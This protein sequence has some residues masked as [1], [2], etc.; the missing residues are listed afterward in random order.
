MHKRSRLAVRRNKEKRKAIRGGPGVSSWKLLLALLAGIIIART[1]VGDAVWGAMIASAAGADIWHPESVT[2]A[3]LGVEDRA[4]ET[5]EVEEPIA[6]AEPPMPGFTLAPP[7]TVVPGAASLNVFIYHTH[8]TE[9]YVKGE[10]PYTETDPWRTDNQDYNIVRVGA[11]LTARL[12]AGGMQVWH[13]TRNHEPPKVSTAYTRSLQTMLQAQEQQ[14]IDLFIDVHRDAYYDDGNPQTVMVDGKPAAKIMFVVATGE[15]GPNE[16]YGQK[17]DWRRNLA[18][19]QAITDAIN[20]QYPGLARQPML[21]TSRFNQHV[22]L[23][24]LVEVGNNLDSL[25]EALQAIA[26]L[27]QALL[28]N[29]SLMKDGVPPLRGLVPRED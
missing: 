15:G 3:V 17:P 19:A 28:A 13:S 18:V 16:S 21:R 2:Q 23:C 11:E 22:G 27:A 25:D 14:A 20:A 29:V 7:S 10:Q 8:T 1:Q 6:T 12:E 4:L 5:T 26:P 24:L 9:A